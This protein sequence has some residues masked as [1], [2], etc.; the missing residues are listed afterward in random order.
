MIQE[1]L[2]RDRNRDRKG[3]LPATRRAFVGRAP[4]LARAEAP[5]SA[6]NSGTGASRAVRGDRPTKPLPARSYSG[7][8]MQ[9]RLRVNP[10]LMVFSG[11]CDSCTRRRWRAI[12]NDGF[13]SLRSAF[14]GGA[15]DS[16]YDLADRPFREVQTRADWL[17]KCA[18][19][20][21]MLGR[22]ETSEA[23]YDM[24]PCTPITVSVV[25]HAHFGRGEYDFETDWHL[26]NGRAR[27]YFI[28]VQSPARQVCA[29]HCPAPRP[30][31][32]DLQ[33]NARR[34]D[35]SGLITAMQPRLR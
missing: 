23:Q 15:C 16:I 6:C 30:P 24:A 17:A 13:E 35:Y 25:G 14:N 26:T 22:W 18:E 8:A 31:I 27:L 5:A 32:K 7:A 29:P 19:M 11:G 1:S 34:A 21:A 9:P 20:R 33:L 4:S 28:S 2:R 3:R 10:L 12:S